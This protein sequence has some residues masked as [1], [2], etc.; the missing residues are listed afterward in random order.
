MNKN[1]KKKYSIAIDVSPL[2][3]ANRFRG[4]GFYTKNLV[5]SLQELVK[6]NKRYSQFKITLTD[7]QFNNSAIQQSSLVHYPY[8]DIFFPTLPKKIKLTVVTVHDLTPLV[9]PD[10]YPSGIRGKIN[11]A[12]QK[13][14]LQ[15]ADAIITDS[16]NSKEDIVRL[17]GYLPEKIFVI[18][19]GVGKS[20]K[21]ITN[22]KTKLAV[23]KKYC[24]P[25]KFIFYVGDVNWN[26]NIPGL[27][28]AC[29]KINTPL[30]IAGK[31]AVS[32]NYDRGH[33]ENQDLVWLQKEAQKD[34]N[35]H[36]LGFVADEDLPV[37]YNLAAIYCQPSFY[38]GFGMTLVEAM[39]CGTPTVSA[40][41]GSLPEIGQDAVLYFD[42]HR[43]GSLVR[44]LEA[45]WEDQDL[46]SKLSK[47]GLAQA[48]KFSWR[49]CAQKTLD[50]YQTT[51][52]S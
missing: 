35:I 27:V 44:A 47:R 30:V 17:V 49:K 4:V 45:V 24:L 14:R 36:L 2:K 41:T 48:K 15:A 21:R 31:Q 20:F 13:K 50:V 28:K 9:F 25:E 1:K 12:K 32:Q 51:P 6:K 19:L 7:E 34:P 37:L 18:F 39:A 52:C 33:L 22:K 16:Q 38:E 46:A 26:K 10:H 40:K 5:D 29:Q 3:D 23:K 8:F 43:P 42:P 11:W